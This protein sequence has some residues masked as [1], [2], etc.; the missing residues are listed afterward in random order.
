VNSASASRRI[1]GNGRRPACRPTARV[2]R[3]IN[4]GVDHVSTGHW[5]VTGCRENTTRH[6]VRFFDSVLRTPQSTMQYSLS[7]ISVLRLGAEHKQCPR[8]NLRRLADVRPILDSPTERCGNTVAIDAQ[9]NNSRSTLPTADT[10]APTR[11]ESTFEALQPRQALPGTGVVAIGRNEGD[12]LKRCLESVRTKSPYVVYVDSGSSDGSVGLGREL[13]ATVVELDMRTPF[14]AARAR[15]E[16]FRRLLELKDSLNYVFF[17]DGDCEVH[18]GWLEKATSFL[19][20]HADVGVVWGRLR[21]QHPEKSVY[22]MLCDLDWQDLPTG[23]TRI[24]GG[25]AVMRVGALKQ[26]NGYRADL[27]CGEEPELCIRLRKAGWRIWCLNESMALHDVNLHR[28]GQWWRRSVRSG[29]AYAQ[30]SHLHGAAPEWHWVFESRRAWLWGLWIPVAVMILT[31]LLGWPALIL[32]V[33]YPFQLVRVALAGTRTR[34]E[35]WWR[36]GAFVVSKF[37]EAL[38]QLKYLSDRCRRVQSQLIEYK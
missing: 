11:T 34:R 12:R 28:F 20:Q 19:D 15:N 36:A 3:N 8:P 32:L 31:A 17:V 23:E 22:N 24:C 25:N 14:T 37:P 1:K 9:V 29:Y 21:E 4:F 6:S 10:I 18:P 16:G 27:I 7:R 38:G 33:I 26:V 5:N 30:G 2:E 35:N 13:G